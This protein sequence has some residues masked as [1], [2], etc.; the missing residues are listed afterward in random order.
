[1]VVEKYLGLK[2]L[3]ECSRWDLLLKQPLPRV[4]LPKFTY[5]SFIA[6][7]YRRIDHIAYYHKF[8]KN[9]FLEDPMI[10]FFKTPFKVLNARRYLPLHMSSQT[11]PKRPIPFYSILNISSSYSWSYYLCFYIIL[12]ILLSSNGLLKTFI[13]QKGLN[14]CS[15]RL[16]EISSFNLTNIHN[17]TED[18]HW[19]LR[20]YIKLFPDKLEKDGFCRVGQKY[21]IL[22]LYRKLNKSNLKINKK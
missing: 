17:F 9:V 19:E 10:T 15:I 5:L 18:S 11:K 22:K 6:R 21:S 2:D 12:F 1:M 7:N 16:T 3:I 4:S 14:H 8:I 13:R 20:V